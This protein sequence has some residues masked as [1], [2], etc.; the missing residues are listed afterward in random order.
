MVGNLL[1]ID[2]LLLLA[3][4]CAVMPEA[5]EVADEIIKIELEKNEQLPPH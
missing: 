3:T 4:S 1:I 5:L 2:I